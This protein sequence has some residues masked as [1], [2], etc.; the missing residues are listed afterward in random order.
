MALGVPQYAP[1]D[2]VNFNSA[3]SKKQ[4][5]TWPGPHLQPSSFTY[6]HQP[7]VPLPHPT[8]LDFLGCA[9]ESP[10]ENKAT[11]VGKTMS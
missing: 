10:R 3:W 1:F 4:F 2:L 5:L 7:I 11:N 8:H 6:F 9:S